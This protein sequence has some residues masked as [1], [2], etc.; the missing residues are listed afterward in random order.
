LSGETPAEAPTETPIVTPVEVPVKRSS[1]VWIYVIIFLILI[2]VVGGVWFFRFNTSTPVLA[3]YPSQ[4]L[5]SSDWSGYTVSNDLLSPQVAVTSVSGSWVIPEI[6]ASAGDSYSAAWIGVGGQ[7][8]DALIQ[9]GTV[10]SWVNGAANYMAWYELLP[11]NSV[12]L[13]MTISPG[14]VMRASITLQN[15]ASQTW[16]IEITDTSN[17]QTFK[18]SFSYTTSRLSAEWI[19]ERPIIYN[20]ISTFASFGRIT[21]KDCSATLSGRTGSITDFPH[22]TFNLIGRMNNYLDAV[23][24]TSSGGSSFAVDFIASG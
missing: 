5:T 19:V 8:D 2:L 6:A 15:A 17:G 1:R 23:S 22:S 9:T 16:V 24:D 13:N 3:I 12:Q 21:F 7:Y 14:D 11:Q 18:Q 4:R 20:R 10:Q